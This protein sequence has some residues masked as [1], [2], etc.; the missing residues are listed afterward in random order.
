M[1]WGIKVDN[2]WKKL[3][4]YNYEIS[5]DGEVRNH[6]N[7]KI[8]KKSLD[9]RGYYRVSLSLGKRGTPKIAFIHRL[10]AE[11]FLNNTFKKSQVNHIDG[12]KLNN[13]LGNL[14]W[15]TAKENVNHAIENGLFDVK[16]ITKRANEESLKV[17][18]KK[19]L[20][21]K[22]DCNSKFVYES[23]TKCSYELNIPMSTLRRYIDKGR[24][25]NGFKFKLVS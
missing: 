12:N 17:N 13:C 9:S 15:C 1:K 20:A 4:G 2:S 11:N 19:V 21:E 5:K 3:T 25:V 8:L 14:E 16:K 18:S 10:V 24:V 6:I 7:K 23:I 22:I